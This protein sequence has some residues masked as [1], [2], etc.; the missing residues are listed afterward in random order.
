MFSVA[1][2]LARSMHETPSR[3]RGAG[4][5]TGQPPRGTAGLGPEAYSFSTSRRSSPE[6]AR[7]PARQDGA[8]PEAGSSAAQS[9]SGASTFPRSQDGPPGFRPEPRRK[10]R[11]PSPLSMPRS[12]PGVTPLQTCPPLAGQT[13]PASRHPNRA[14]RSERRT[15]ISAVAAGGSYIMRARDHMLKW[16]STTKNMV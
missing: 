11:P 4:R 15:T 6:N 16:T 2:A 9:A 7:L 5:A 3:D 1:P 13:I 8:A 12:R 10:A 14:Y